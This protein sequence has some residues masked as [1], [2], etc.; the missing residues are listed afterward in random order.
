V[1][2]AIR[3]STGGMERE[4]GGAQEPWLQQLGGVLE[5]WRGREVEPR[6]R[7]SSN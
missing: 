2:P 5:G 7:G 1:A 4:R 3:W 6:S